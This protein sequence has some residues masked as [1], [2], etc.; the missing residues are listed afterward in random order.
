MPESDRFVLASGFSLSGGTLGGEVIVQ[1]FSGLEMNVEV[2]SNSVGNQAGGKK[3]LEPRP[4]PTTP[5]EPSFVCPIPR[6]DK[7]LADWWKKLNPNAQ[8]GQYKTE[9]LMF[10]FQGDGGA[11]HAQW[12]LKGTFPMQYKVSDAETNDSELACETIQLCV[13]EIERMV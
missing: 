8:L 5:G 4:G 2:S 13:T 3:K 11:V 7:K 6:N 10:T 1:S 9:D 12:Q